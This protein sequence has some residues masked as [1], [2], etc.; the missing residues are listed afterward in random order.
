[1]LRRLCIVATLGTLALAAPLYAQDAGSAGGDR[2]PMGTPVE[3]AGVALRDLAQLL[4]PQ[5]ARQLGFRSVE[6]AGGATLGVALPRRIVGYDRLLAQ[7]PGSPLE[8]LFVAPE[9]ALYPV[10]AG[11]APRCVILLSRRS[12]GWAIASIG[13]SH[14]AQA[15]ADMPAGQPAGASVELVSVPGLNMDFI[16]WRQ[17]ATTTLLPVGDYPEPGFERLRPVDAALFVPRLAAYAR[18]FDQRY[19]AQLRNRKLTN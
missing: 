14:I 15:L 8:A 16:A 17:G 6:E 5:N 19:G 2:Q 1:M 18:D 7:P 9:Q 13:D 11:G 12:N 10:L 3:A 4:D